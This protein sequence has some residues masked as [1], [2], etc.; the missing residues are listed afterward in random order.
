MVLDCI[1]AC[2]DNE[3]TGL[4]QQSRHSDCERRDGSLEFISF[5][6]ESSHRIQPNYLNREEK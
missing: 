1:P 5:S 6:L 4:T 3:L 2:H